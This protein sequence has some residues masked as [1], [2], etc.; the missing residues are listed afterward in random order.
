M[1]TGTILTPNPAATVIGNQPLTEPLLKG[2]ILYEVVDNEIR[3][4]PPM[5]ARETRFGSTLVQT[6]GPFALNSS[7]GVV[8]AEMLFLL[9][10]SRNL[11][12]RPDVSFVSFQRWPKGR[13]VPATPAWEVVPDLAVE[14]ISA[15]NEAYEVLEKLE[16]YFACG[17]K[18]VWVVYPPFFKVYDYASTT[19]VRILSRADLLSG[20]EVVPGFEVPLS[21]L[22]ED[23]T[24][25]A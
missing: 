22:F 9:D 10:K 6:M 4:L 2:D 15:T 3:E 25:T 5:S 20:G 12:R 23:S 18:R 7:L 21:E 17:V 13:P 14:I 16:D 19:S 1:A 24:A 8:D 11:Q